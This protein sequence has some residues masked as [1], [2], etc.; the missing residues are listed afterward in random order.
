MACATCQALLLM[1]LSV[2]ATTGSIS[3]NSISIPI[4][5][6][7]LRYALAFNHCITLAM[8]VKRLITRELF[9]IQCTNSA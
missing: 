7:A 2:I 4:P 1:M 9:L 8:I 6:F 5:L 3:A